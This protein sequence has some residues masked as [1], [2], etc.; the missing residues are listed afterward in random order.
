MWNGLL[1]RVDAAHL[2]QLTLDLT[3]IRSYTGESREVAHFYAQYLQGIGLEVEVY[4]D[5]P[6]APCVVARLRGTGTGRTLTLNGHLDTVPLEHPAPSVADGRV[7]GRGTADMKGGLAAMAEAGRVLAESG[8]RLKGDLLLIAHGLHEAPG[9]QG[10]DLTDLVR[11]GIKGDAAIIAE[12]ASDTLPIIGLGQFMFEVD[13]HRPGEAS[14][15]L[16]TPPG[17]PNPILAAVDLAN[18]IRAR[19]TELAQQPPIPFI[20]HESYFIGIFQ[21]G[22]FFNR[23]T[24]SCRLV[25]TR[26]YGPGSTFAAA[27]AELEGMAKRV[28]ADTGAQITVKAT[29]VRDGFLLSENEPL[30]MKLRQA[31]ATVTG[32]EL[33]LT[34]IRMVG[35]AAIFIREGSIP[36]VYHGPGG[37]GAHADLESV[38]VADLVRAARVYI[39]TA[40]DYIGVEESA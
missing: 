3:R 14:H 22:D 2:Q 39:H 13:A 6:Q 25:G 28:E 24:T 37:E 5:Y 18:R 38:A 34:G 1:D 8:I 16:L 15:E 19:Q 40:M 9:G 35:D 33:P 10:Q 31:Y 4:R 26:R 21:G 7:Y 20:G 36:A 32:R 27:R 30:V 23:W 11:R 12:V 29:P 17:T